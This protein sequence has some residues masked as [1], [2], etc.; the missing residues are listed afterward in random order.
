MT[1]RKTRRANSSLQL[2]LQLSVQ[3]S[4]LVPSVLSLNGKVLQ[5]SAHRTF[6]LFWRGIFLFVF[7]F[8]TEMS[9][10]TKQQQLG[11]Q[12]AVGLLVRPAPTETT[13]D[14][15]AARPSALLTH[16]GQRY[17]SAHPVKL[18]HNAPIH[19]PTHCFLS[20]VIFSA[21]RSRSDHQE[22]CEVQSPTQQHMWT[23]RSVQQQSYDCSGSDTGVRNTLQTL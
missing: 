19:T 2:N 12:E 16:R 14:A 20:V 13:E 1:G 8:F 7:F 17:K 21:V 10:L 3:S 4:Q 9:A 11:L 22:R 23:Q 6:L 18:L 15:G 5:H